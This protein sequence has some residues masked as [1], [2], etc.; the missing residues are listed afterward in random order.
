M[1][2]ARGDERGEGGQWIASREIFKED[3]ENQIGFQSDSVTRPA[4]T[5]KKNR[6]M[7]RR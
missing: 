1:I 5:V 6:I 2:S 3:Q 4:K 7:E